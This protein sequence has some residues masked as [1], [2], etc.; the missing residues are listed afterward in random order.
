MLVKSNYPRQLQ[1]GNDMSAMSAMD[2]CTFVLNGFCSPF[3]HEWNTI[4][5]NVEMFIFN[6][7]KMD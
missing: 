5:T 3:T 4:Y 7:H 6:M 1:L 2:H